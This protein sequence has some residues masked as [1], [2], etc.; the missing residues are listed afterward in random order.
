MYAIVQAGGHQFRV[1]QGD[2]IEVDRLDAAAGDTIELDEVLLVG[3]KKVHVG[4][5]FVEGAVD[6]RDLDDAADDNG[7]RR[8]SEGYEILVGATLDVS[9]VT[10][11]ELSGGYRRQAFDDPR[12]DDAAGFSFDGRVVW[13][14]T[15][16]LSLTARARR[17]VR[18]TTVSNASSAFTSV[19]ALSADYELLDN[20]VLNARLG[21]EI[22]DFQGIDREDDLLT[23]DLGARYLV[24]PNFSLGAT[25]GFESRESDVAADDYTANTLRVFASV[26]F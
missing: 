21:Y 5:P 16:L 11:V 26:Q 13:N 2:I 1:A 7:F 25:Y 22:E 23:F 24:G 9:G 19:F 18:E 4:T 15:D 3:G 8:D 12:L 10:F 20:L 17:L 6:L 14:P